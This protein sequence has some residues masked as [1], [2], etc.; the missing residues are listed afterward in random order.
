MSYQKPRT[1]EWRQKQQQKESRHWIIWTAEL[2]LEFR[3]FIDFNISV[4]HSVMFKFRQHSA[5]VKFN[6]ISISFSV[7]SCLI[8]FWPFFASISW[9]YVNRAG[10]WGTG[11]SVSFC[12]WHFRFILVSQKHYWWAAPLCWAYSA[13]LLTGSNQQQTVLNMIHCDEMCYNIS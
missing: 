9:A 2:E 3:W 6:C 10:D 12:F 8:L 1:D 11:Y 13:V 7:S 4:C 5:V